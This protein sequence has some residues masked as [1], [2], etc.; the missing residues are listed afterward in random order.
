[1]NCG[2]KA[3][4]IDYKDCKNLTIK[5]EDGCIR[6]HIRSDHFMDGRV[7]HLNQV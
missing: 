4:V 2:L 3:T 7:Q 1:M 5:F 6:E